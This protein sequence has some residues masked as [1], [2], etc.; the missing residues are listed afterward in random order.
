M[1]R[2]KRSLSDLL[3]VDQGGEPATEPAR[4]PTMLAVAPA[5]PVDQPTVE[6]VPVEKIAEPEATPAAAALQDAGLPSTPDPTDGSEAEQPAAPTALPN[7]K[8]ARLRTP[9]PM[10]S[11]KAAPEPPPLPLYLELTRK[12]ARFRQDQLNDLTTL[13][14]QLNRR[15]ASTG[16]RITDNTLIRVAVDMMLR[17]ADSLDGATE[18]EL[19]QAV[20]AK[21]KR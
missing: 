14:R 18:A 15:R 11:I 20:S 16:D 10:R 6:P 2:P 7:E 4:T 19:L 21:L 13:T 1:A 5:L 9:S 8:S 12:E 17:V 3:D